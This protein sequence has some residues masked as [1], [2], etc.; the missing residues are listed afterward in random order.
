MSLEV[1]NQFE[2]VKAI[3][4]EKIRAFSKRLRPFVNLE[5]QEEWARDCTADLVT[6]DSGDERVENL[7]SNLSNSEYIRDVLQRD[8]SIFYMIFERLSKK[9]FDNQKDLENMVYNIEE[10]VAEIGRNQEARYE[11][12]LRDPYASDAEYKLGAYKESLESQVREAVFI[13]QSKGYAP[14]E[15]GFYDAV[16]GTQYIGITKTEGVSR[17]VIRKAIFTYHTPQQDSLITNW[18]SK[19]RIVE[20][21]DRVQIFFTPIDAK[22]SLDSWRPVLNNIAGILPDLHVESQ[23]VANSNNFEFGVRFREAQDK[24]KRGENAWLGDGLAFVNGK[25]TPM[26]FEDYSELDGLLNSL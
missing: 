12:I 21:K 25:V 24:I 1:Q 6:L 15:S 3:R 4:L 19:I 9:I 13:L 22:L 7:F 8:P 20:H 26:T 16:T 14:M 11:R 23:D 2:D 18:L 10:R 17:E 5:E